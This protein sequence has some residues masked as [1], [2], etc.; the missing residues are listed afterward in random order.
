MATQE[1][2]PDHWLNVFGRGEIKCEVQQS[3][4]HVAAGWFKAQLVVLEQVKLCRSIHWTSN[5][6]AVGIRSAR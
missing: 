6:F 4:L 2:D 1:A 5:R 3:L